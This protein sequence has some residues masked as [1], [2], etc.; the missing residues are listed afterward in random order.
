MVAVLIGIP[1]ITCSTL[2]TCSWRES[3][4]TDALAV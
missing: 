2:V 3:I 4:I 1:L